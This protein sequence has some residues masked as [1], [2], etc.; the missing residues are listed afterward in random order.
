MPWQSPLCNILD[1]MCAVNGSRADWWFELNGDGLWVA[2]VFIYPAHYRDR[3]G[4][5]VGVSRRGHR[6]SVDAQEDAVTHAL[7]CLGYL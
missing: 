3:G 6:T 2:S 7:M 5:P 1:A 4:A